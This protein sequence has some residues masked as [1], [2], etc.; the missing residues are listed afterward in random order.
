VPGLAQGWRNGLFLVMIDDRNYRRAERRVF[1]P[2]G[3]CRPEAPPDGA[4][5]LEGPPAVG[6]RP[7]SHLVRRPTMK[8]DR[9]HC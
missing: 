9:A 1:I 6:R 4:L 3:N 8:V 5:V 7:A 2:V